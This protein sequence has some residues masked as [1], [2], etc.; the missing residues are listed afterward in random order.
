MIRINPVDITCH[1]KNCF[2]RM[3]GK[4]PKRNAFRNDVKVSNDKESLRN[5]SRLKATKET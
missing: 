3:A 1:A 4:M 2:G 5:G